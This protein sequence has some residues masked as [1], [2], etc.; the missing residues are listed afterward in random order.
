MKT[1]S[2]KTLM[3]RYGVSNP[4]QYHNFRSQASKQYSYDGKMFSSAP[5][6]AYYIWLS[7]NNITFTY[8]PDLSFEYIFDDKRCKYF[9]D[10]KVEDEIIEIKGDQFFKEDGIMFCPFRKKSWS[11][12]EY[13]KMCR[14]YE[15]KH[16]CMLNNN[17]KILRKNDYQTYID[18]VNDKYGKKFLRSLKNS[19]KV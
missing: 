19:T 12:D 6:V 11:D 15:A 2:I 5:E 8:Q 16:Q 10:F 3:E 7:D 9:P 13:E 4:S 17:V 14:K 1:K 18:Y